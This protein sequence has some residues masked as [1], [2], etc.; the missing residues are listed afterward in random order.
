[1]SK[2]IFSNHH[3]RWAL[4]VG[5]L[6]IGLGSASVAISA[7]WS[8]E[9][10]VWVKEEFNDN[11]RLT[12]DAHPSVFATTVSPSI[13]F[14]G[15]SETLGVTGGVKLNF[16]RFSGESALNSNDSLFTF[17]S[18]YTAEHDTLGLDASYTRDSTLSSEFARTGYVLARKQRSARDITPSWTRDLTER[19][20]VTGNYQY[21]DVN[22][23][24][25]PGLTDYNYQK[26]SVILQYMWSELDQIFL[27]GSYDTLKYAPITYVTPFVLRGFFFGI[28]VNSGGGQDTISVN[29]S[30]T[31]NIMVGLD[32]KFSESFGAVLKVGRRSTQSKVVHTC[33]GVV[34]TSECTYNN[35]PPF[36]V[37]PLIT[38]SKESHDSGSSL[39]ASLNKQFE[40]ASVNGLLSRELNASGSGLVETDRLTVSMT[41]NFSETLTGSF[42]IS[43]YR[44]RY[45]GSV[46]TNSDSHYFSIEPK[47]TWRMTEWWTMATGYSY[48]KQK[49]E[50]L[51]KAATANSVYVM[52]T[53]SWPKIS[54]SR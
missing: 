16:N 9:P 41:D 24:T 39:E 31:Q 51:S 20:K 48:A 34:G 46:A 13:R 35:A 14:G 4:S 50:N 49:F 54:I 3:R 43:N 52:L 8:L 36:F 28:P 40:E 30:N 1:M 37:D 2:S 11:I 27:E 10:S 42:N 29:D 33:N 53:Y 22:Y 23:E 44:T 15:N 19:F 45:L 5:T 21:S 6:L 26:V 18:G 7:E 38:F 25:A 47:I 17:S 32:H 12:T